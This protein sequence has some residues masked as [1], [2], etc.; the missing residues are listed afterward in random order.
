MTLLD[1]LNAQQREAVSTTAGPLLVFAGAGSGKTRVL[2]YRIAHILEQGLAS[3]NEMLVVTFTNKAAGEVRERV[4]NLVASH[5]FPYLGTFH[6]CCLRMLRTE[7]EAI[8]LPSAFSIYDTG[9]SMTV[10]KDAAKEHGIPEERLAPKRARTIISNAKNRLVDPDEF[11][12][13]AYTKEDELAAKI[14]KTYNRI[15][16][17]NNALDFD[18]LLLRTVRMLEQHAEIREKYQQR[19][20]YVLVDEYQDV[21]HAQ[22]TLLQILSQKHRNICVVGDDDQSIYGFRGADVSFILRFEKDFSDARVVKLEQNYR[23]TQAVLNVANA[24]VTKNENR[25]PKSMWTTN[26]A[27]SLPRLY[28]AAEGRNEAQFIVRKVREL[29]RSGAHQYGDFAVLYRTNAQ[30]RSLEDTLKGASIPYVMVG[31]QRF[32]DRKEIRDLVCYLRVIVNPEDELSLRRIL[33]VPPRSLGPAT[34]AK[35]ETIASRNHVTLYEGLKV[36]E[37][38]GDIGAKAIAAVSELRKMFDDLRERKD[39][40]QVT[41]IIDRVIR[42]T[43]YKAYIAPDRT[44]E[45]TSRLENIDELVNT[46]SGFEREAAEEGEPTTL[47]NFLNRVSLSSDVDDLDEKGGAMSLLTLHAAKGLEFPVVF[48][49]GMEEGFLPHARVFDFPQELEEERRL[50][51]VGMTRARKLLFLTHAQQRDVFGQLQPRLQS[52]FLD[53]VPPSMIEKEATEETSYDDF[54]PRR[55]FQYSED[56]YRG[57][58]APSFGGSPRSSGPVRTISSRGGTVTKPRTTTTSRNSPVRT[59]RVS[60]S[61]AERLSTLVPEVK[62]VHVSLYK[63]GD[64]VVHKVFG[65]GVVQRVDGKTVCA[66]FP[67][68]GE[69]TVV[70]SFLTRP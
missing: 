45:S 48:L 58:N 5:R 40:M 67:G 51:Y 13:K 59:V 70:E 56:N 53:D 16:R 63:E 10:I 65:E 66:E 14:Y 34:L 17:E 27:G 8:G 42:F 36:A 11:E 24:V 2:T 32:W 41:A 7:H 18:D 44:A 57:S 21:N 43:D 23:S 49:I 12:R 55:R 26:E 19:F 47:D 64:K 28:E 9:D 38:Q 60:K 39:Q 35:L 22:Y 25:S 61:P 52:R 69:K 33:N 62:Y 68:Y 3:P 54:E 4:A 1:E 30:S 15:L 20:K 46:A 50:A 6:A 37:N 29:V 31:G